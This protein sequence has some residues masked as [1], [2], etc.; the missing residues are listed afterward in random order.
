MGLDT[1]HNCWHGPYSRFNSFRT[2]LA[3]AIGV[4]LMEM[5]GF[6]GIVKF[7]SNEEEP[8]N[9]LLNHSDCDGKISHKET[10][11]L[12]DRMREIV[13]QGLVAEGWVKERMVQFINGLKDAHKAGED[14]DFH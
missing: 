5:E 7:T 2:E 1:T 3:K 6:G 10:L 4:N 11:P 13:V 12:A 14:V 9:I 8:L